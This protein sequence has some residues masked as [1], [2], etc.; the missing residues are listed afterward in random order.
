[1]LPLLDMLVANGLQDTILSFGKF[2]PFDFCQSI[3][4][5]N[6]ECGTY[7]A[8]T[9]KHVNISQ[10]ICD[11]YLVYRKQTNYACPDFVIN[12]NLYNC[13]LSK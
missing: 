13:I 12:T 7:I 5:E 11:V 6:N 2:S 10:A 8:L 1:M 4:L 3:F 9:Q